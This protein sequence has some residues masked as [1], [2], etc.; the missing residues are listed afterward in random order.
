MKTIHSRPHDDYFPL[1]HRGFLVRHG[2]RSRQI[3]PPNCIQTNRYHVMLRCWRLLLEP[4][5][6]F[7]TWIPGVGRLVVVVSLCGMGQFG[8]ASQTV[9]GADRNIGQSSHLDNATQSAQGSQQPSR[10]PAHPPPAPTTS[11]ATD[12]TNGASPLTLD[13]LETLARENNPTVVQAQAQIEGERAKA[14][15]AGLYP[16]PRIGYLGE[17][18]GVEGTVGEFQGGFVQQEIVTAGKLRLSRE[19]YHARA[20]AAEFQA[21]AQE[22]RVINEVRIRYY[23]T[24]GAQER[25]DIRRE[26]LKTAKDELLTV[27]EMV[28]V[29][30]A[31]QADLH[32]ANVLLEDHQ[33]QATM[34]ENDLELEWEWLMALVGVPRPRE[35]LEGHLEGEPTQI[36]WDSALQRVLTESPEMGLVRAILKADEIAVKREKVEPIPNLLLQ[37][38]AGHNFETRDAV[39]GVGASIELPIFDWNQGTIRQAQADLR[40]QQAEVRL[41]E[42]R[43]RRS[44]ATQFQRYRTALRQVTNYRKVLLPESQ[45]RYRIRLNSYGNNR[46][47]WPAVLDAQRDFFMRRLR[48]IDHLVAWRSTQVTIDGLLLVD[49]LMPPGGVTLPGHIDAVPKPR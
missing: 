22:Y 14:L 45:S 32:Q 33:L 48:Y 10:Q 3:T 4:S 27:Q 5:G 20:S 30:Q 38:S 49:G 16:N 11:F 42:L 44:L 46:Q 19:K 28:N 12:R 8:C 2:R 41:T 26:L 17:Q 35:T 7:T 31:N 37:G 40:R 25:L 6:L 13:T 21:L 15:Q 18:I 43:L 47:A 39:F 1:L 34:A 9:Q 36:H 23:R 24:L 29:G